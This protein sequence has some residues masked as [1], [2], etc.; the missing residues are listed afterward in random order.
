LTI[1]I[2][3]IDH[4]HLHLIFKSINSASPKAKVRRWSI[5]FF[6]K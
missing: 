4:S 3:G 1:K 6:T 2:L 5:V